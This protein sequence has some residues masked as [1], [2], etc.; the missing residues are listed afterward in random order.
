M[1]EIPL[2]NTENQKVLNVEFRFIQKYSKFVW[3]EPIFHPF[4]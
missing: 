3:Q 1:N 4:Y 2:K